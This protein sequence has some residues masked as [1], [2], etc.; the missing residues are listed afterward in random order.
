MPSPATVTPTAL[1]QQECALT[2]AGLDQRRDQ[3][4]QS[5]FKAVAGKQQLHCFNSPT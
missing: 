5:R 4:V 1:F 3:A 2:V